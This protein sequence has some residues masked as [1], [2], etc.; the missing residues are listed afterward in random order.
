MNAPARPDEFEIF[1]PGLDPAE[2]EKRAKLRALRNTATALVNATESDNARALAW[3]IVEYVT[4]SL[5]APGAAYALDELNLLCVRLLKVAV[6]IEQIDL[7]RFG[8]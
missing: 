6:Q 3:M 4:G 5:F 1:M 7:E 8:E 2:R